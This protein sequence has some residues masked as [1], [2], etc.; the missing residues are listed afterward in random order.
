MYCRDAK[1][2]DY[3]IKA[4]PEAVSWFSPGSYDCRPRTRVEGISNLYCAGDWVVMQDPVK[5][6]QGS[7]NNNKDDDDDDEDWNRG[8][9]GAKGLCQERAY[10]SGLVAAN[11]ILLQ[12]TD[13]LPLFRKLPKILPIRMDEPQVTLGRKLNKQVAGFV[14]RVFGLDAPWIR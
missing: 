7:N 5:E 10:V 6:Q 2:V 4:H 13:R 11:R 8:E 14:K 3:D 9:H 12:F 1:V